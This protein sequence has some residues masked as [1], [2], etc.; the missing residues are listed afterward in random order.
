MSMVRAFVL[1]FLSF[2]LA[3]ALVACG[4]DDKKSA[5]A[6][7]EFLKVRVIERKATVIA[8]PTPEQIKS[9]G[10]FASDYDIILKFHA[11][12][13]E[14]VNEPSKK[15]MS[16]V[17]LNSIDAILKQKTEL[18]QMLDNFQKFQPIA[19][20]A[21]KQAEDA[22][23]KLNQPEPLKSTYTTAFEKNVVQ[24]VKLFTEVRPVVVETLNVGIG[25][26]EFVEKNK[27]DI[28]INGTII[29]TGKPELL[30]QINGFLAKLNANGQK[31]SEVQN[32]LKN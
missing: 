11:A 31:M 6:L 19:D 17:R 22:R 4:D 21:L 27:A 8:R 26:A 9:F 3:F 5:E 24:N 15:L 25:L 16:G 29:E 13:N 7:S 18:G 23:A 20:A 30:K 32:K 2:I 14:G 1:L 10:R 28:K 12:M